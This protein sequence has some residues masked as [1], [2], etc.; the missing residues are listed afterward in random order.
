MKKLISN[1]TTVL[2]FLLLLPI[3]DKAATITSDT[4]IFE[5]YIQGQIATQKIPALSILIF[6]EGNILYENYFGTSHIQQNIALENDHLFL[7]ASVSKTIT[8]TALLQ[9][10]EKDLF[11]LDDN[12]N[13]YLSFNVAIPNYTKAITFRMLLTHTSG[14]ADGSALDDQYYYREDSPVALEYF[15]ENYL[16]PNGAFYNANQNFHDF[17]PGSQ[18]E[19]SNVGTALIGVLV[20]EISG[21]NFNTYCK[22]NIFTPLEM[23]HTS[24][25]LDEITQTIVQPYNYKN[26]QYQSVEHYTFTDYPNGGLRSTG[27]DMFK[28]LSTFVQGGIGNN[29]QLLKRATIQAMIT[30]QI[31]SID[32]EMGLHLFH[33]NSANNLWGHN[34]GEEGTAT[35]MAFNPITKVGAII[36]A[37]QGEANLD[38][39]LIEAYELGI[40]LAN[41][42][43]AD[44]A[45]EEI[46]V[47][48]ITQNTYHASNAIN[49]TAVF[50]MESIIFKAANTINLLPGF[51]AQANSNFLATIADCSMAA[52]ERTSL[53]TN[54]IKRTVPFSEKRILKVYPNP[55]SHQTTL[56]I[57]LVENATISLLIY[58][59][60]GKLVQSLIINSHYERGEHVIF[61]D[62]ATL[63][64]GIYWAQLVQNQSII[65]TKMVLVGD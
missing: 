14:I 60:V 61:F 57:E 16:V 49:S 38:N 31:P 20:Q 18:H 19:Y 2:S 24:W 51:H 42:T 34:G 53:V 29:Y 9:L 15:I 54:E 45:N 10:Y 3:F 4:A 41:N 32:N 6:K 59:Q 50:N 12:V 1:W 27:R 35:I 21:L 58:N 62:A 52:N 43:I 7:L 5:T 36:L 22:Q 8:A 23:A 39:I 26:G 48:S 37:N 65:N 28:F 40:E 25:R 63:P 17:E 11:D 44:C 33:L 64:T 46:N 30:P 56:Q 55:F 13:D 47:S